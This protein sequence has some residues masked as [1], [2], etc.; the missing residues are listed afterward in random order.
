[1]LKYRDELSRKKMEAYIPTYFEPT[2]VICKGQTVTRLVE[3]PKFMRFVFVNSDER[4]IRTYLST[5][6][7]IG[8][9]FFRA[10]TTGVSTPIIVPDNQM[11]QCR[12][13]TDRFE[14]E[15]TMQQLSADMVD[16]GDKVRILS[17]PFS[18]YQGTLLSTQGKDGGKVLVRM[19]DCQYA[20]VSELNPADIAVEQFADAS[21]HL[22]QK[23]NSL[24]PRL[25]AAEVLLRANQPLTPELTG[26][27]SLFIRRYSGLK[28]TT[29][30][31]RAQLLSAL[32]LCQLFLGDTQQAECLRAQLLDLLAE[33]KSNRVA[34]DIQ[35]A[36][37]RY[38][39]V[40]SNLKN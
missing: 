28:V 32:M 11:E 36:I 19:F 1:M 14:R 33:I 26:H 38:Y 9:V 3:K 20:V 8:F 39:T 30:N 6:T 37:D 31:A 13:L 5:R 24:S 12:Q 40:L 17:G 15:V 7:D 34:E 4:T 29:T 16:K 21:H 35:S 2:K 18:G 23:L 27:L 10:H 22:Y 25:K